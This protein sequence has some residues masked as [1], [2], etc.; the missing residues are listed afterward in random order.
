MSKRGGADDGGR[1][2]LASGSRTHPRGP[3]HR[4]GASVSTGEDDNGPSSDGGRDIDHF[5][6]GGGGRSSGR[7]SSE[8]EGRTDETSTTGPAQRHRLETG[9][10]EAGNQGK[11][12]Q[13]GGRGDAGLEDSALSGYSSPEEETLD[14]PGGLQPGS[15]PDAPTNP[16][17]PERRETDTDQLTHSEQMDADFISPSPAPSKPGANVR[18]RRIGDTSGRSTNPGAED[19]FSESWTLTAEQEKS[20]RDS[21]DPLEKRNNRRPLLPLQP[22]SSGDSPDSEREAG[23]GHEQKANP[24]RRTR[25]K[26]VWMDV[27]SKGA[28]GDEA[29]RS[30]YGNG[31][32]ENPVLS[33]QE[34]EKFSKDG[35][36]S[37]KVVNVKNTHPFLSSTDSSD[38]IEGEDGSEFTSYSSV[39]DADGRSDQEEEQP[40]TR[41]SRRLRP[42]GALSDFGSDDNRVPFSSSDPD[43]G[44]DNPEAPPAPFADPS[45]SS[46]DDFLSERGQ[47][48]PWDND[49]GGELPGRRSSSPS[50]IGGH[51]A[52][53]SSYGKRPSSLE[54]PEE[55]FSS[56]SVASPS[57]SPG[58]DGGEYSSEVAPP[59]GFLRPEADG[60]GS[61]SGDEEGLT[62]DVSNFSGEIDSFG[63]TGEAFDGGSDGGA[64]GSAALAN[65]EGAKPKRHAAAGGTSPYGA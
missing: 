59:P 62:Q 26:H 9:A 28:L 49:E 38:K 44:Q 7:L 63:I 19:E 39:V 27:D 4:F 64:P 21:E 31:D 10:R 29:S 5:F 13:G 60:A 33:Q 20:E 24:A 23:D 11:H 46:V 65:P 34:V 48:L 61:P 43:D 6:I 1:G 15:S 55:E 58:P 57:T 37:K 18:P 30:D 53:A 35:V 16:S 12:G 41:T 3:S 51:S 40:T 45:V 47:H 2:S 56:A 32:E 14:N 22:S 36:K 8:E 17:Q 50:R 52:A 42:G 25:P 54:Q